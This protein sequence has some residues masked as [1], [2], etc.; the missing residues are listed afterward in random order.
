MTWRGVALRSRNECSLL[1]QNRVAIETGGLDKEKQ[2][3][4][5]EP[6]PRSS[7]VD[8]R[9]NSLT[10]KDRPLDIAAVRESIHK[11]TDSVKAFTNTPNN[12]RRAQACLAR[13]KDDGLARPRGL[14]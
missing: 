13:S 5:V 9:V 4:I 12:N 7:F 8:L 3:I 14:P 6:N 1:G 2:C 11:R 10:G